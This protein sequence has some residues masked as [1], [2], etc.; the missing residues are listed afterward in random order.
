[1]RCAFLWL[2]SAVLMVW[3]VESRAGFR[4]GGVR[5][6][7]IVSLNFSR[8]LNMTSTSI[9][10]LLLVTSFVSF[11]FCCIDCHSYFKHTIFSLFSHRKEP[12]LFLSQHIYMHTYIHN[13]D[14]SQPAFVAFD[15]DNEA[16]KNRL[17]VFPLTAIILSQYQH[18]DSNHGCLF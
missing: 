1:M 10:P 15:Y 16:D 12:R 8:Y 13:H 11:S 7:M 5:E 4:L 9:R 17:L 2:L 3:L 18:R 6:N 14:Q